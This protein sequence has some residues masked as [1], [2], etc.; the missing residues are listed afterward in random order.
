MNGFKIAT[1]TALCWLWLAWPSVSYSPAPLALSGFTGGGEHEQ[2][3]AVFGGP[4]RVLDMVRPDPMDMPTVEPSETAL[5]GLHSGDKDAPVTGDSRLGFQPSTR[6]GLSTRGEATY[7]HPSLTGGLMRDNRT[8]YS[9]EVPTAAV[10][11]V[12]GAPVVE[13]GSLLEVCHNG[14]CQRLMVRDTGLFQAEN[15][16]LS[17]EAFRQFAPLFRGRIPITWRVIDN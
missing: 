16:D 13:L 12:A 1:L 9:P 17:E 3:L 11:D 6:G 5:S 7:Y 8:R 15:L 14:A 4:E 10:A 2:Y